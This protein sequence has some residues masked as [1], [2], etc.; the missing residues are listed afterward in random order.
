MIKRTNTAV[1]PQC[2]KPRS[3]GK[4]IY[5]IPEG[6]L[7]QIRRDPSAGA[8]VCLSCAPEIIQAQIDQGLVIPV[9][10]NVRTR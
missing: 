1:C 2:H 6:F 5:P 4:Y 7:E 3:G 9:S 8:K 10:S